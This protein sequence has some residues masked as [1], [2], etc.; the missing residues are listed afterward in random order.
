MTQRLLIPLVA[1]LAT[2]A[3]PGALAQ[4]DETFDSSSVASPASVGAN[5]VVDDTPEAGQTEAPRAQ[6]TVDPER[7]ADLDAAM[8][9]EQATMDDDTTSAASSGEKALPEADGSDY[10]ANDFR[11]P[12][13]SEIAAAQDKTRR[14]KAAES[15]TQTPDD[16]TVGEQN[17]PAG[18]DVGDNLEESAENNAYRPLAEDSDANDQTDDPA[19]DPGDDSAERESDRKARAAEM[20]APPSP[21]EIDTGDH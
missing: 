16:D 17:V 9:D 7:K 19:D 14:D 3:S 10:G 5:G 12:D 15:D 11:A 18:K 8:A 2:V 21:D 6:T 13:D 1:A 20:T 4:S